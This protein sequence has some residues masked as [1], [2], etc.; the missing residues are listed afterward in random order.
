MRLKTKIDV[1]VLY[2][3]VKFLFFVSICIIVMY[4]LMVTIFVESMKFLN[5]TIDYNGNAKI[6]A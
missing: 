3:T 5:L 2:L 1:K 4:L 6:L